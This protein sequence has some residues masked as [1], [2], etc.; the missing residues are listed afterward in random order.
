MST[1]QWTP[2]LLS[3]AF[4]IGSQ[5]RLSTTFAL[6]EG[7]QLGKGKQLQPRCSEHFLGK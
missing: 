2:R 5:S 6:L 1:S 3:H 4:G 7:I